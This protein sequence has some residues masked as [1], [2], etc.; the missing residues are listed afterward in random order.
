MQLVSRAAPIVEA[1]KGVEVVILDTETSSLRPH[2]DGRILA[3]LGVKPL[4][5][6]G[7]YLPIRHQNGA[8][9]Q[10][11]L[12]QLRE[13]GRALRGKKLVYHNPKFDWAVLKN[14]GV[15]LTGEDTEDTVVLV[16]I[17]SEEERSYELKALAKKYL[18]DAAVAP[19][20]ELKKLMKSM[21]WTTYDQVPAEMILDYVG[22]DLKLTE[23]FWTR[24]TARIA[25]LD[26]ANLK[27]RGDRKTN[28]LADV[29]AL[30]KTLTPWLFKMEERGVLMD[31][32]HVHE[33]LGATRELVGGLERACYKEAGEEFNLHSPPQI[34]KV[35]EAAGVRSVV[36]TKKGKDSFSK[37]ALKLIDHPL[38]DVV[39]RFRGAKNILD[40]Y[41][42]FEELMDAEGVIHCSFHQA[43]ARTGRFSCREP[44]LQNIPRD[45]TAGRL[46][47]AEKAG[48]AVNGKG[49][50]KT[51]EDL[52]TVRR[53][54]ERGRKLIREETEDGFRLL[55][56]EELEGYGRVR[57]AFVARPGH[58]LLMA[59][60][61][62]V[63]LRVLADYAGDQTMIEAFRLG[64]DIHALA[65]TAAYG[66]LPAGSDETF[67]KW[68]RLMGKG[69]NFGLVYGMGVGLL[70]IKIGKSKE[71][72]KAFMGAY[73]RRFGSVRRFID[74]T[75][76][77]CQGKGWVKNK[78]GRRRNLPFEA[79]YKAPN[80][81][82]QGSSAD[83]MKERLVAVCE[84]LVAAVLEALP[85]LT[86][87]DELISEI[88][89]A[90]ARSAIPMIARE[91]ETCTRLK[92]PLK[93]DLKWS[94]TN[95]ADAKPLDCDDCEGSG[96][97]VDVPRETL[98]TALH[99]GDTKTLHDAAARP[100]GSCVGHGWDLDKIG[101]AA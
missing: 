65:A 56:E 7:F 19:M 33:E 12:A 74:E 62:Q 89:Y 92:V 13:V 16:R 39:T 85:L 71:E 94:P 34:R 44:N 41:A 84:A 14:D 96:I 27:E 22:H 83:L 20:R 42:Q 101:R 55:T 90:E 78:W 2:R 93:V 6:E 11:S 1:L 58:F 9:K 25:K 5:G 51:A 72:A 98:I 69:I 31:R 52:E 88:P 87:H 46:A 21:G 54:A 49:R 53:F 97:A 77:R 32:E 100:C 3:G 60:W 67:R 79:V 80:F 4:G 47:N 68:W 30:E 29:L 66:P 61:S 82:V 86:I 70:A 26:A 15:D 76:E 75:Q 17:V 38:A 73:F 23:Y 95:W 57:K 24:A 99:D 36:K 40:Y 18:G 59:D 8:F 48:A 37:D 63:E 28:L 35:F 50:G 43:G 45:D 91:M 10:A 64:L 81:L